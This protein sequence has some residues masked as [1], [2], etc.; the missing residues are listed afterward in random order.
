MLLFVLSLFQVCIVLCCEKDTSV[1]LIA[2]GPDWSAKCPARHGAGLRADQATRA[3]S[4]N[5][6]TRCQVLVTVLQASRCS[7]VRSRLTRSSLSAFVDEHALLASLLLLHA[8]RLV[9][10]KLAS[11]QSGPFICTVSP[12]LHSPPPQRSHRYRDGCSNSS[13][14]LSVDSPLLLP[15]RFSSSRM[16]LLYSP[17]PQGTWSR[18]WTS[19]L[20]SSCSVP[21]V[22]VQ[23]LALHH[24]EDATLEHRDHKS[25]RDMTGSGGTPSTIP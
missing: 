3:T 16:L 21:E 9:L 13:I 2:D 10:S 8:T 18:H 1:T 6:Q 7:C 22:S 4:S 12:L 14:R 15:L 19:Y 25:T 5:S 24:D 20:R 17:I 11:P 23:A